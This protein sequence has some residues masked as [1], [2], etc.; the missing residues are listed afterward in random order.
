MIKESG[1]RSELNFHF[2]HDTGTGTYRYLLSYF[3]R[4]F[5]D[6]DTK[7]KLFIRV[8]QNDPSNPAG[9]GG[10]GGRGLLIISLVS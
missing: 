6:P 4:F 1:A 2:E 7:N 9:G 3:N 10:Q 5:L 8:W